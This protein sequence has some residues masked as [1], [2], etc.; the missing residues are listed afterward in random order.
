MSGWLPRTWGSGGIRPIAA[1]LLA[2][3]LAIGSAFAADPTEA[4]AHARAREIVK[5]MREAGAFNSSTDAEILATLEEKGHFAGQYG[6]DVREE[7]ERFIRQIRFT[8]PVEPKAFRHG[9][10]T[11]TTGETEPNDSIATANPTACG[12]SI[13]TSIQVA[14]D[15]DFFTYTL[16]TGAFVTHET[17]CTGDTTLTLF[18]SGGTQIGFDDDGGAGLCSLLGIN[19]AAG[20]YSIRVGEFGDNGTVNY[21]LNI[22]CVTPPPPETEPND[23]LA[24]AN[25]LPCGT[26]LSAAINPIADVDWFR[27]DVPSR[28]TVNVRTFNCV[29]DTTMFLRDAAGNEIEFDDDDGDGLCSSITR[30]LFAGTYYLEVH[31]FLDDGTATY[32]VGA[33][34]TPVTVDEVEPNDTFGTANPIACGETKTGSHTPNSDVDF[35]GFTLAVNTTIIAEVNCDGD[36]VLR[37]FDSGGVQLASDNDSGP[38]LCSRLVFALAPGNYSLGINENGQDAIFEYDV[39]L[40]CAE[41]IACGETKNTSISVP[42][43]IDQFIL[44]LATDQLVTLDVPCDGDAVMTLNDANG[45]LVAFNDDAVGLCPRLRLVLTAGTYVILMS[46]FLNDGTVN[47]SLS[48]TC[49]PPPPLESEPNDDTPQA[50]PIACGD[51]VA[52]AN[53]PAGDL[54]FYVV[55]IAARSQ[56]VAETDCTG[57]STLSLIDSTITEIAFDDNGGAGLCSRLEATVDA[58]TYYILVRENGNDA[59]LNYILNVTCQ[60]VPVVDEVEPNDDFTTANPISCGQSQRG[61]ID[62]SFDS[63]W[64]SFTLP[65]TQRL[66][67]SVDTSTSDLDSALALYTYD[68]QGNPLK[69]RV[70]DNT[71]DEDPAIVITL[72]PG[73]YLA[74]VTGIANTGAFSAYTLSAICSVPELTD[75]GCIDNGHTLNGSIASSGATAFATYLGRAGDRV[76]VIAKSAAFDPSILI[77]RPDAQFVDFDDDDADLTGAQSCATLPVDGLYSIYVGDSFNGTGAF[78][79]SLDLDS[80]PTGAEAEPNNNRNS[81]NPVAHLAHLTATRSTTT[82]DDFYRFSGAVNDTV[83]LDVRTCS[84]TDNTPNPARNV[85]IEI[86]NNSNVLIGSN[87]DDGEDADPFMNFVLPGSTG[88]Y[89]VRVTGTTAGDYELFYG[90]NQVPYTF[91]PLVPCVVSS[92]TPMS[93]TVT[94]INPS[95]V[96]KTITFTVD[97]IPAGGAPTRIRTRTANAPAGL[98]KTA[99]VSLGAAPAVASPTRYRY[100]ANVTLGATSFPV[101]FEVL[102]TP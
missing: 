42:G 26:S 75:L 64:W 78:T 2:S 84:G 12:A 37:L 45:N 49:E 101:D 93:A 76:R 68:Q 47:Y 48:V 39:T 3:T 4:G 1:G 15:Q 20:T 96:R 44:T 73:P 24:Q 38:G 21:T 14:G 23:S 9:G 18:D 91:K 27:V 33:T 41:A 19:L 51:N 87:L 80:A 82:D 92:G 63:D 11:L 5:A 28:S 97:R 71:F 95:P 55:T 50:N 72:G 34:C 65:S 6:A 58:G 74:E 29:T 7:I 52:G 57:D 36:S 10:V 86:Y 62:P 43:E 67:L 30:E 59:V 89:F 83:T 56:I 94:A 102:V 60:A 31:E 32:N 54:D 40:T 8:K 79:V 35:W 46:E 88:D 53:N 13:C 90:V 85:N 70:A 25:L 99:T 61:I 66:F 17:I 81:A 98:N 69:L 16:G 22:T 100:L 77:L